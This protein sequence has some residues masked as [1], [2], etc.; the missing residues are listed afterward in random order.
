MGE[1]AVALAVLAGGVAVV[2]AVARRLAAR[3]TALARLG[4][5][6]QAQGDES[7]PGPAAASTRPF[8]RRQYFLP[9]LVGVGVTGAAWIAFRPPVVYPVAGG[10]LIGL[11]GGELDRL[12]VARRTARIEEQLA[13]AI[14]LMVGALQAGAGLPA[15]LDAAVRESRFPLRPQLA[16]LAGR[17]RLGA[18]PQAA[19]RDLARRVPLENV[20]L[21]ASALSV[22]WEVGG[23]LA[24]TLAT[25]GRSVRDRIDL[26]RRVRSLTAQARASVL[27]V[28]GATYFIAAIVWRNDP[29][30][31]ER[32]LVHPVGSALV[33]FAVVFQAVGVVWAAA[34][35]RVRY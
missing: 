31:M 3:G 23:S 9:W 4:E 15:A 16:E 12:R 19:L 25:V 21:F 27:A 2:V 17:I 28:L 8:V 1:A 24:G 32:F 30:R 6:E 33:G 18:D 34:V 22:H 29:P 26:G 13:D 5:A 14:D 11:L 20:V 35:S 10:L 7:L